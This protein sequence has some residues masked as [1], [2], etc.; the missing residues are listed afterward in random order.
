[1]TGCRI[2]NL[3]NHL[4]CGGLAIRGTITAVSPLAVYAIG[5]G[6]KCRYGLPDRWGE[7]PITLSHGGP[8]RSLTVAEGAI[9]C[10]VGVD[11]ELD[12][13]RGSRG[14]RAGVWGLRL[15]LLGLGLVIAGVVVRLATSS[16]AIIGVGFACL[17]VGVVVTL[18]SVSTVTRK[19]ASYT[20]VSAGIPS[21][22]RARRL[23]RFLA[24]DVLHRRS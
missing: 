10:S 20:G 18:V 15:E 1:M 3:T 9:W 13:I 23:T 21:A 6:W 4:H 11:E 16:A 17:A 2:A 5:P 19:T 8:G 7:P 24:A 22:G 12:R 14:W